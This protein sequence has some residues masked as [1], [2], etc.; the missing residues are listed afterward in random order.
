MPEYMNIMTQ[1]DALNHVR[2]R[3]L[4]CTQF[5]ID[6][7]FYFLAA[8]WLG[9]YGDFSYLN[10]ADSEEGCGYWRYTL[11]GTSWKTCTVLTKVMRSRQ[12]SL[13]LVPR[14]NRL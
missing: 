6:G 12:L 4:T 9:M 3:M 2:T 7:V 11:L 8:L 1:D 13:S 10:G 14:V 5:A